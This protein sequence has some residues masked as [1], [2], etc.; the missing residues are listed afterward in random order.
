MPSKRALRLA[1]VAPDSSTNRD[2]R[3]PHNAHYHR[4]RSFPFYQ[5]LEKQSWDYGQPATSQLVHSVPTISGEGSSVLADPILLEVTPAGKRQ[6][7]WW[8]LHP[9]SSTTAC[10]RSH[11][12]RKQI[13]T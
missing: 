3:Q 2:H 4:M 10:R 12:D 7:H 1:V 8:P 9:V 13:L 5:T 6:A 11:K